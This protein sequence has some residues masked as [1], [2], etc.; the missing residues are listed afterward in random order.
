MLV[1]VGRV[2]TGG[3]LDPIATP[4]QTERGPR[5]EGGLEPFHERTSKASL[6]LRS[7]GDD[8]I[9][10]YYCMSLICQ[11]L[12]ILFLTSLLAGLLRVTK[13]L[14]DHWNGKTHNFFFFLPNSNNMPQSA[15]RI[16]RSTGWMLS[17]ETRSLWIN[18]NTT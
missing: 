12:L 1:R 17:L 14:E 6:T 7:G 9:L 3:T 13:N 11:F 10:C 5:N 2:G 15:H 8:D 16:S 4:S 18:L